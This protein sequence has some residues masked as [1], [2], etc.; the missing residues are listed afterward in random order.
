MLKILELVGNKRPIHI[1]TRSRNQY[2]NYK[3]IIEIKP[4]DKYE[5]SVVIFDAMLGARN[6]S[7]IDEVFTRGSQE[8]LDVYHIN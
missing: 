7:H 2:T 3:T 1:I 8:I 5:G 4:I 6:S